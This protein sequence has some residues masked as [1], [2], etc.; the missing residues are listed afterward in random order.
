MVG[1]S[2][3][4][5]LPPSWFSP[6]ITHTWIASTVSSVSLVV[7]FSLL[8][9]NILKIPLSSVCS[10]SQGKKVTLVPHPSSVA[11]FQH[12]G[13]SLVSDSLCSNFSGATHA[14]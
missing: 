10:S 5:P 4:S 11:L 8:P 13:Q 3:P 12:G 14:V 7:S 1:L 6:D 2:L 9:A